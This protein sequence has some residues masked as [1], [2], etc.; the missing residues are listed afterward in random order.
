MPLRVRDFTDVAGLQFTY[1]WDPTRLQYAFI[2]DINPAFDGIAFDSTSLISQG[3]FTFAW[4][5][6]SSVTLADDEVLLNVA[7]TRIGGPASALTFVDDPTDIFVFDGAF[8]EITYAV[9]PGMVNPLDNTLP[10]IN[11]PTDTNVQSVGIIAINDIAPL[12]VADDCGTPEVG[13]SSTGV[14]MYNFPNDPDASGALFN[15]GNSTVVYQATD[16][17]GNTA[18]C[19]FNVSVEFAIGDELTFLTEIPPATCGQ[20]IGIDVIAYNFDTIAAFQFSMAW[21]PVFL[22]FDSVSNFNP[23]LGLTLADFGTANTGTGEFSIGW[24]GPFSGTTLADS[25][26]VYTLYFTVLG[27]GNLDFGDVPT[28]RIAFSGVSFPPEEVLMVTV[29]GFVAVTDTVPP[30]ITCP[31]NVFLTAPGSPVIQNIAP[32]SVD[33]NCAAPNVGWTSTGATMY[34]QPNDPDASGETFNQGTSILTYTTTDGSGNSAT[35]SLSITIE[36]MGPDP[37]TLT[38]LANNVNVDCNGSFFID[39]TVFNFKDI[40]GLQFSMGWDQLLMQ[41]DSVSSFNAMLNLVQANFGEGFVNDGQLSFGWTGPTTGTTLSNDELLFRVYLTLL[42]ANGGPITFTNIPTDIAA[43]AGPVFPPVDIPVDSIDGSVTVVDNMPPTIS[44]PANVTT[45]APMGSLM[46]AV[47][48]LDPIMA[49]NC[50]GTPDLSYVQTGATGNSGVGNANGNYNAGTTTV[51]YTAEDGNNNTATCSFT[52]LVNADTPV[53]LTIDSLQVD[54]QAANDTIKY[55]IRVDN[56]TNIVGLQFGLQWDTAVLHIVPPANMGYPG[57]TLNNGMFFNYSTADDGLLLFFG[58][59]LTWPDIPSGDTLFC[60][61]FEVQDASGTTDLTFEAP[62]QAVDGSFSAIPVLGVNGQFTASGDNTP[63]DIICPPNVSLVPQAPNCDTI[64]MPPMPATMDACGMVDTVFRNPDITLFTVGT[65]L[66]TYTA[67]D[68]AGNTATCSF[69]VTVQDTT[70]PQIVNCPGNITVYAAADACNAPAS[71]TPPMFNDCS[72]IVTNNNFFPDD[73]FPVCSPTT[74]FYEATDSFGNVSTCQFTVTAVDTIS[75]DLSCPADIVLFPQ[76]SCDTIVDFNPAIA[77]DLCDPMVD[78]SLIGTMVSGSVFPPGITT[79]TWIALD[80]CSNLAQCTFSITIVDAAPPTINGCPTDITVPSDTLNCGANVPWIEPTASDDCDTLVALVPTGGQPDAFFNVGQTVVTYTATDDSGNFTT[81]SFTVTVE[82]LIAPVLSNCP[83]D[84]IVLVLPNAVCDTMLNWI[85]PTASD[86]CGSFTLVSNFDPGDTFTTGDTM[87]TYI[88]T[89]DAGNADSCSFFVSIRDQV[90]PVLSNCPPD[91]VENGNGACKIPIFWNEPTATDNCSVPIINT[92]FAPGDSFMVGTTIVQII[93]QD[94]SNNYDT[95]TF[96]VTVVGV[97]PG[98]DLATIPPDIMVTACDTLLSWNLPTPTG[99]CDTVTVSSDPPSPTNFGPGVHMVTFTATDGSNLVTTSFTITVVDDEVPVITCPTDVV[100]VNTGGI[101]IAGD[102]FITST[103]TVAGCDAIE[104][105]F[106][107]PLATDNCATPIV[108]QDMGT[109]TGGVFTLGTHILTFTATDEFGNTADCSVTINVVPLEALDSTVDPNPGCIGENVLLTAPLIQSAIYAWVKLPGTLLPTI[110][111]QY[112]ILSLDAQ[113]AGEY[114]VVASVN[115]CLTPVDTV[116]VIL[117]AEPAPMDDIFEFDAGSVDTFDVFLNDGITNPADYEICALSPDPLPPG[118][119][120]LGNGLFGYQDLTGESVSFAYQ[121]CYCG[122]PGEMATVTIMVL[123]I[124]CT[125]IPN[126]I[127]PNGDGLNDWFKIP[128]LD[129]RTY[130]D[131]SLV[132][133]SQWGDKVFEDTGYTNDPND[134][135]HPAWRGT[136]N[137]N[138]GEDLPDGVYYYIFKPGPSE[139]TLKGFIE[140][141]R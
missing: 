98:F 29:N 26:V 93:A 69:A 21:D 31:A 8:N 115:G 66:V 32:V 134:P 126:I 137:G 67:I 40:V 15:I 35:C 45:D 50:G 127:T 44:C 105:F 107:L 132:V 34:D 7:F 56:F 109:Q 59:I 5:Q 88:V 133:Y 47:G 52:V 130:P 39:V 51:V 49:D 30:T 17:V 135:L 70:A 76:T 72:P 128:C 58:S 114:A 141:I 53:I 42:G 138:A 86:N 4:S 110:T 20:S 131:N 100:E 11:C 118:I 27:S 95:C 120:P 14:S 41:Y 122:E 123:D 9:E 61:D 121:I 2:T 43:L 6:L 22:A 101:V 74:V 24:S 37:N 19:S 78:V 48:N 3:K 25:T 54:C 129:G 10:T 80:D 81:C 12:S 73:N 68:Q 119:T 36:S 91:I 92:P 140:I 94:A 16:I 104:L 55:C 63:P 89:D 83:T 112:E 102:G 18:T 71:W 75:P 13:W 82:D 65:T 111:N 106:D 116:E 136:L 87:V 46:A 124:N 38:L 28:D 103:D 77:T 1:Q 85:A 62:L 60:L 64:Y 90:P 125:F 84:P 139:K 57:L 117:I 79:L 33:D 96:T 99:F 108:T 23:D 97:P 113:S